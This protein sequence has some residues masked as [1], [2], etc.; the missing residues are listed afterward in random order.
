LT[1]QDFDEVKQSIKKGLGYQK[2]F[3]ASW[4]GKI[5][6]TEEDAKKYYNE[7]LREF[8]N[9][10]QVRASHILI[11]PDTSNSD[12][13][14]ELAKTQ[15]KEKAEK[16]LQQVKQGADF[17]ELAKANSAC[18]SAPEGGDLKYFGKGRMVQPF[19]TAAFALKVGQ[20]SEVVETQFGYHIIK[21]TDSKEP[22]TTTFEQ[23]KDSIMQKLTMAK[24][25]ELT[26]TYIDELKAKANIVY[27]TSQVPQPPQTIQQ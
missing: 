19:E 4:E 7:N 13:P 15:A 25:D 22:S 20:V 3:E 12:V 27:N 6:V 26:K 1:S 5:N 16:L 11:K 24:K 10:L 23:A 14:A 17:A 2:V 18:P 21:V 8:Q 9:E